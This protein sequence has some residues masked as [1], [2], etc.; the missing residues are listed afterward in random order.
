[1]KL[2]TFCCE[3]G[4]W[5]L[6]KSGKDFGNV[7]NTVLAPLSVR[8]AAKG[9]PMRGG[10]GAVWDEVARSKDAAT[11]KLGTINTNTSL[12]ETLD[13]AQVKKVCEACAKAL[14]DLPA[15]HPDAIGVAITINGH[16]EEVDLYPN[17][18]LLAKIYPRLV[19]SYSLVACLEK[20]KLKGKP[21]PA[22][23]TE[24]V[25]KVMSASKEKGRRFEGINPD[26]AI[27][28]RELEGEIE[29]ATA[30]KDRVIHRQWINKAAVPTSPKK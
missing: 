5:Q 21:A 28:C 22:V 19:Q 12:N 20:D 29:F 4:R 14:N 26:N 2:P 3:A 9:T 15:K 24:D 11:K 7:S 1:M 10:Q 23:K 8:A 16:V 27:R 30:Y 6:G 13:S 17:A 18:G 25:E